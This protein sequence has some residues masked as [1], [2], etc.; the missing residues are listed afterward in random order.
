MHHRR[1]ASRST[2]RGMSALVAAGLLAATLASCA[3]AGQDAG[4]DEASNKG[5]QTI[6]MK[7]ADDIEARLAQYAPTP[8]EADLSALTEQDRQVLDLLV[9]ASRKLDEVFLRQVWVG[10]PELRDRLEGPRPAP[11]APDVKAALDYY[12]INFGPWDRL[13]GFEPFIGTM[14]HPEGAGFYPVDMTARRIQRVGRRRT[15]TRR[16]P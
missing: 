13:A 3:P 5:D 8:L 16:T 1:T 7:I 15:R 4:T 2:T 10:N 11:S 6:D 12:R 14:E 9:Q